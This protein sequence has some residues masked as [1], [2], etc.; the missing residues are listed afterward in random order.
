MLNYHNKFGNVKCTYF[1]TFVLFITDSSVEN[2]QINI[3][4]GPSENKDLT[5]LFSVRNQ[6]STCSDCSLTW[7]SFVKKQQTG[8]EKLWRPAYGIEFS[9]DNPAVGMPPQRFPRIS[10]EEIMIS[11]FLPTL[12][13]NVDV[14]ESTS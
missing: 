14:G 5:S 9:H 3:L 13:F 2:Q 10:C 12:L 1:C 4:K 7:Q 6:G 11:H 8:K